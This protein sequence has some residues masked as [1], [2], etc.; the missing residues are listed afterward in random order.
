MAVTSRNDATLLAA[1]AG[2]EDEPSDPQGSDGEKGCD[3][4]AEV[5]PCRERISDTPRHV[6][7]ADE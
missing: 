7:T 6:T 3:G 1:K 2:V 5:F 4:E